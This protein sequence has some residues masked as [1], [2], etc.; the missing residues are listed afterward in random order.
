[1]ALVLFD[2][3]RETSTTSG[4]GTVVLSNVA[5]TGYQ[6]FSAVV[7]NNSTTYYTI[8]DQNGANWEVG[9]GTYYLNN[10]SLARTTVLSS[11]NAGALTNFTA[12]THDVFIT[13]PAEQAVYISGGN[14]TPTLGNVSGSY[15]VATGAITGSLATGAYSYGTLPYSDVNI[16]ASYTANQNNYAQTILHNS[17]TGTLASTDFIVGNNNTTASTFYGDFGI[18]GGGFT[19]TGSF[20]QPNY[21]FLSGTSSDLAIGTTTSNAIHFVVN[22]GTTDAGSV[23]SAGK[24]AIN[25]STVNTTATALLHLGAGTATASSAPVKLSSGVN[26][27]TAEAGA[28]EYDGANMYGTNDTTSGRGSIPIEQIYK[29]TANGTAITTIA[30]FFGTTSNIPVVANAFYEIEIVMFYLKTTSGTVTWTLTN[31]AS[32]VSQNVYYEMSPVTGIVTPPGTATMLTG[33]SS[34]NTTAAYTVTTGTLTSAVTHYARFKVWLNNG[35]GT[36][37]KIQAT[38]GAGNLTPL[39]GSI[40]YCKRLPATN[41]GTYAA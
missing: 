19:G 29:L 26:L 33:Q 10:V 18:N 30:N 38:A 16:F 31:S 20:N 3:V 21:V 22:G 24:W 9:L 40:W 4:T 27:T 23:S 15:Y 14:V 32:P 8:A 1:M 34:N 12:T 36:S 2:R 13:Y 5:A 17:S 39:V 25:N 37:V 11:S 7:A 35:S 6:T 41:V 28:I